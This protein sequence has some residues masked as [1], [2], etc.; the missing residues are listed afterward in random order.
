MKTKMN[1]F[2]LLSVFLWL[3]VA[4][5]SPGAIQQLVLQGQDQNESSSDEGS[6]QAADLPA[7]DTPTEI[8]PT[9]TSSVPPVEVLYAN[10]YSDVLGYYHVV[11]EV[12]NTSDYSVDTVYLRIRMLDENGNTL[13]NRWGSPAETEYC[14]I[15][16]NRLDPGESSPFEWWDMM[17]EGV[18]P[19]SL[20]VTYLESD[21]NVYNEYASGVVIEKFYSFIDGQNWT[22]ITG[23]LVNTSDKWIWINYGAGVV[24]DGNNE[25]IA[26]SNLITATYLAPAGDPSGL[27]R[28]PFHSTMSGPHPDAVSQNVYFHAYEV[29]DPIPPAFSYSITDPY[30]YVDGLGYAHLFAWFENTGS[31]P[32]YA[33]MQAAAYDPNGN[34]IA[35]AIPDFPWYSCLEVGM[36]LPI[37]FSTW[38]MSEANYNM[39]NIAKQEI[40]VEQVFSVLD[41]QCLST[42]YLDENASQNVAFESTG[43]GAFDVTGFL[44]NTAD[45]PLQTI[46]VAVYYTDASGK[47]V[48][49]ESD[50]LY[51]PG[52]EF[53]VGEEVE[54]D[55]TLRMAPSA[56]LAGLTQHV[57]LIGDPV[58]E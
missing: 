16:L 15:L 56:S 45:T 27:D 44:T 9:P 7:E 36:K 28:A 25:V 46:M 24:R 6:E 53:A 11:G 37:N 17:D 39:N 35:V 48:G 38:G 14:F 29:E 19:A 54:F 2:V 12:K 31:E 52:D 18:T 3:A 33:S 30:F 5:C 50:L 26:A 40:R 22:S 4:A 21:T 32:L 42:N 55:V 34:V 10:G 41:F 13:L 49:L 8:I 57:L 58:E 43:N 1:F 47:I 23:E 51:P 20:E